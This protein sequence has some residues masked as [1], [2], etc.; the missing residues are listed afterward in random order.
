MPTRYNARAVNENGSDSPSET[1]VCGRC[2]GERGPDDHFCR[3]CGLAL[4]ERNLPA[5]RGPNTPAVWRPSLPPTVVR[6][7]A[8][9]AAGKLAEILLRRMARNVFQR[10]SKPSKKPPR[11][12]K[13]EVVPR[14]E[15]LP[16]DAEVVSETFFMRRIRLRR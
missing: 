3:H 1:L 8:V 9:V 15:Q 14:D 12:D 4:D 5:V 7:A 2:A 13:A 11:P 10:E 16:E 6:G